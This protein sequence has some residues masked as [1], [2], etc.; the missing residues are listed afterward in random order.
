MCNLF[1]CSCTYASL[2]PRLSAT[3]T[4]AM[5]T[6]NQ[7]CATVT[8]LGMTGGMCPPPLPVCVIPTLYV[9]Y[10]KTVLPNQSKSFL[11]H[12][13]VDTQ[14]TKLYQKALSKPKDNHTL[15]QNKANMHY[16][17]IHTLHYI[18]AYIRIQYI[19]YHHVYTSHI[20]MKLSA[21]NGRVRSIVHLGSFA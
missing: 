17:N 20:T 14:L 6:N 21:R 12:C 18:A 10:Y 2:V 3:K 16:V 4:V 9:L 7:E 13:K 19:S 5:V 8:C 1:Y 15:S 11:R